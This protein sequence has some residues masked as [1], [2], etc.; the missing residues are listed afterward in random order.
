[1]NHGGNPYGV[2][3]PVP[4][5]S[6][7]NVFSL[8]NA[9]TIAY[10]PFWPLITGLVYLVYS[11]MGFSDRFVYYFLLKQPVIV[12]DI[13]LGYLLYSFVS[14]RKPGKSMWVLL[15][16]M[17]SPFT[18]ILSGIWGM[19]D[20]LAMAFVMISIMSTSYL[21]R[22]FWTGLGVFAKSIPIIYAVPMTVK[23]MRDSWVLLVVVGLPAMFS[24]IILTVRGWPFSVIDATLTSAA[25]KGGESMSVWDAFF[26]LNYVGAL[27]P[28]PPNEYRVLG[29]LWVPAL[30]IFTVVAHRKY[31]IETEYGLVQSLILVTLGFLI[32]KARVTEQYAI[33]LLAL[34]VIDVV[35][36]NPKRKQMLVATM[37]VAL[38]YLIMNNYFLI[39]FLSPVYPE[40]TQVESALYQLIGPIRYTVNFLAGS[41]FTYLNVRYLVAVLKPPA[42]LTNRELVN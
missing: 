2:L 40:Y 8:Q 21:R 14:S 30:A 7:A 42:S 37:A 26:Y 10:L 25:A 23:R 15:F 24:L 12:G 1:M 32:F 9:P 36:W 5:L 35:L 39:R 22:G 13:A 31:R 19:F 38:I 34:S 33:Y 16:W 28:L 29:L 20:S 17:L 41:I 3:P 11:L 18:I 6:F 4:G 27:P